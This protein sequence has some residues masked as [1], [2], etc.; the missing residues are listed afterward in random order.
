VLGTVW[1]GV[2]MQTCK[3][4]NGAVP[5]FNEDNSLAHFFALAL[6]LHHE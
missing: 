3:V 6:Q 1:G 5:V 4:G 2:L